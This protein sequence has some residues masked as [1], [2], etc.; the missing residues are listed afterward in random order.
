ML[1][2]KALR[3][4]GKSTQY[5][6]VGPREGMRSPPTQRANV[7]CEKTYISYSREVGHP[8]PPRGKLTARIS[9][10]ASC[11]PG[12]CSPAAVTEAPLQWKLVLTCLGYSSFQKYTTPEPGSVCSAQEGCWVNG[13]AR[14][15]DVSSLW[16]RS[17]GA[18][19]IILGWFSCKAFTTSVTEAFLS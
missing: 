14:E 17:T 1:A 2:L 15:H 10:P 7:R 18:C 11:C 3:P 4:W 12:L 6:I 8:A 13:L 9:L 19:W 16:R 5:R